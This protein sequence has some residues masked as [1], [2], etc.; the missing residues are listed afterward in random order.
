V[1]WQHANHDGHLKIQSNLCSNTCED[2]CRRS[3]CH[4]WAYQTLFNSL[5]CKKNRIVSECVCWKPQKYENIPWFSI[6]LISSNK[7][8][9]SAP[10][11]FHHMIRWL[12]F[13]KLHLM[14]NIMCCWL[15]WN[16]KILRFEFRVQIYLQTS[17]M[18]QFQSLPNQLHS[19]ANEL[20]MKTGRLLNNCMKKNQDL[21][22]DILLIFVI[23]DQ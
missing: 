5:S 10:E 8:I 1:L 17:R 22:F 9:S 19:N 4:Q 13:E 12:Q 7:I 20:N 2:F 23:L 18:S 3:R 15:K 6:S 11:K 16:M 14:T 21:F